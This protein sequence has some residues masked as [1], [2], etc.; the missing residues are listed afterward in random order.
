MQELDF[1]FNLFLKKMQPTEK[2]KITNE[3][4]ENT[5]V[6][7]YENYIIELA[8]LLSYCKPFMSIE[9][10]DKVCCKKKSFSL[11]RTPQL[12]LFTG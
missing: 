10:D 8:V 11:L 3:V 2:V 4:D 7:Y 12:G 9:F 5:H 1:G 6:R